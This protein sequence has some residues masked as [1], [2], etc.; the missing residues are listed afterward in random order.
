LQ[1]LHA[2]EAIVS[3]SDE[4]RGFSADIFEKMKN[5]RLLDINRDFTSCK[6][7]SLPD[8]LRWLRWYQYPFS[9]LPVATLHKLVGL[10]IAFGKIEHIWMGYKVFSGMKPISWQQH[11]GIIPHS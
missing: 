8:E 2:V 5:I 1:E 4:K 7:T 9:S 6:P 3:V 10:E 11:Y